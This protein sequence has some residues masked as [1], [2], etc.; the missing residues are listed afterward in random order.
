MATVGMLLA[1]R[2][3]RAIAYAWN[4]RVM[5]PSLANPWSWLG[6]LPDPDSG[7]GWGVPQ[8]IISSGRISMDEYMST[9]TCTFYGFYTSP[10][11]LDGHDGITVSQSSSAPIECKKSLSQSVLPFDGEMNSNNKLH[12][13]RFHCWWTDYDNQKKK[14]NNPL[15]GL[16]PLLVHNHHV[17]HAD[18]RWICI[19]VSSL[20]TIVVSLLGPSP[21][22]A[23][24]HRCRYQIWEREGEGDRERRGQAHLHARGGD[25]QPKGHTLR[26]RGWTLDVARNLVA[27][28]GLGKEKSCFLV[29][30][31]AISGSTRV[32]LVQAYQLGKLGR[33]ELIAIKVNTYFPSPSSLP[34]KE[35]RSSTLAGT[36]SS[37]A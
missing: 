8:L 10:V 17:V 27:L 5:P 23:T 11:K 34:A 15:S 33:K 1:G 35:E 9:E 37:I 16:R 14:R 19:A 6:H 25:P 20:Q 18:A 26:K 36:I 21:P 4:G 12:Y 30:G 28:P 3:P 29:W 31:A 22:C 32:Q 24:T 7:G 2:E 13:G